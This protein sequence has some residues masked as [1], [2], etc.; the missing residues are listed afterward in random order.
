M[1]VRLHVN[2]NNAGLRRLRGVG[3]TALPSAT[4]A[5]TPRRADPWTG[6]RLHAAATPASASAPPSARDGLQQQQ[7]TQALLVERISEELDIDSLVSLTFHGEDE[8]RGLAS[9]EPVRSA[10]LVTVPIASTLAVCM[11]E[12]G[13]NLAVVAPPGM[14]PNVKKAFEGRP[15]GE[16]VPGWAGVTMWPT[17][18]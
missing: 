12:D 18:Q 10:A 13:G 8:I 11:D 17:C 7:L 9:A 15:W 5:G 6:P 3:G 4:G 1:N 14:P 2:V 16:A